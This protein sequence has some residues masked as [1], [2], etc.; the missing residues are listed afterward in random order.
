ME[1]NPDEHPSPAIIHRRLGVRTRTC[2]S[3]P[4]GRF[5]DDFGGGTCVLHIAPESAVGWPLA[6][7]KTGD[8]F[9]LDVAGR[10]LE[11]LV[12]EE[13]ATR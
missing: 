8:V 11:L 5:G 13:L 9:S 6:V 1:T 12:E 10:R 2:I 3:L 4:I 7:V